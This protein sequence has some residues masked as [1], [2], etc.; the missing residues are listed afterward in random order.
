MSILTK[1]EMNNINLAMLGQGAPVDIDGVGYNKVDYGKMA[2]LSGKTDLTDSE[3]YVLATVLLKY[4]NTQLSHMADRIKE[5]IQHYQKLVKEVRVVDFNRKSVKLSWNFNRTVSDY[6]KYDMDRTHFK[7][8][9]PNGE[10]VLD[11]QWDYLKQLVDVFQANG[12]STTSLQTVWDNLDELLGDEPKEQPDSIILKVERP[13]TTIDTLVIE[14]PY[15]ESIVKAFKNIP[16]MFY[17]KPTKTWECYIEYSL[18]LYQELEGLKLVG[19]DLSQLKP[20][21]DLVKGW[22]N[23]YDLIDWTKCPLKFQPYDFQIEDSKKLLS[24]KVMLNANDMGCGKTFEQ[25]L[26]GE[27]LPMKKLVICPPTLRI[28]W[29]KEIQH[30]NPNAVVHT[31]YSADD[32]KVVDGWNIIGYNSLDKFQKQLES[33]HFQVIMVDEAH[34]IQAVSNSGTP[35]SKRAYSVLR[36]AATANYVYPIT[37]TPKTNRNKNL[38]NI[39]RTIRHPLGRGKWAFSNYGRTYCDGQNN[40]YGWDYDGNS[41]DE[42]LNTQLTPFMVRHLKSEVLPHLKKQRIVTPV[43]VDLREYHYEISQYLN[44]RTNKNAEDLARLMRAR[45]I[46]ATQK[47]GE[48]ID[49]AKNLI[50]EDKK[51]V[52]VTCFTEVVKAVEKAF[53]GNVVKLVGGMSDEAKDKS[54]IEFQEGK[55]QVMVMNIVAGGVG[56]TLTKSY[57]MVVNDFDWTPGNLTQAEDRICRSGQTEEYCNIYYL[58]ASGADMDEVFADTLTSKFSTINTVVDG[59]TGDEIDYIDLINKAL[60]KSTGVKKVRRMVKVEE[61]TADNSNSKKQPV[62]KEQKTQVDYKGMTLEELIDMAKSVGASCKVYENESIYRMRLV[63]AIKKK[64]ED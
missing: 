3:A 47:V 43:E 53:K 7:W 40:G 31:I 44:N 33:E 6:I 18:A 45:K 30:V 16:Y 29:R 35:D 61:I 8:L 24:Q 50:M 12:F 23:S 5:T 51:V 62:Q 32:F 10:W 42:E 21:A 15:H 54:I 36:L 52:I 4:S 46:L 59:G 17:N 20:W 55:S 13:S 34:Y 60:E 64:V 28:N 14:V 39:L 48:S 38:F 19:L 58:Y 11:I 9:K 63:M 49:F 25:V 27:S 56:V 26:V 37:G 41:N 57:N 22:N 1:Q 2:Y